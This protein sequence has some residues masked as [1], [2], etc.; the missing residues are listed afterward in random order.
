MYKRQVLQ[1]AGSGSA[2]T[3]VNA[4]SSGAIE[5]I[6]VQEEGSTVGTA[7]SIS[8]LNFV[9]SAVFADAAALAGIATITVTAEDPVAMA[10]ALG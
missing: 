4:A 3:W 8:T 2:P 1:S 7:N 6:T 10:I 9:G 5:G